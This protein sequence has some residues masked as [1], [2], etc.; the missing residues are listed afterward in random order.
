[1]ILSVLE[2]SVNRRDAKGYLQKYTLP[3]PLSVTE[4]PKFIQGDEAETDFPT[5]EPP[6]NVAIVKL[7]D[8]QFLD[9]KV[10]HGVGKTLAQLRALGL[11]SVVVVDCGA[12]EG[13]QLVGNEALRLCEAIDP[14]TKDGCKIVENIFTKDRQQPPEVPDFLSHEIRVDDA[15]H[16]S[17]ALQHNLIPILPSLASRDEYAAPSPVDSGEIILALTKYFTGLQSPPVGQQGKDQ[18][19][20]PKKIATVE[21]II[22]LDPLGGT[23]L[24]GRWRACHRF[25]NL[26][27]EYSPLL[28][29]LKGPEGSPSAS[30]DHSSIAPKTHAANLSLIKEALSLLPA[31]SSGLITTPLAA[32][33][34][35]DAPALGLRDMV[36]TR[37][38]QNPLL[39]NLLTDKP[40]YSSS[41]PIQRV[42]QSPQDTISTPVS[43]GTTL[44][45]RGV[46]LSIFPD[47]RLNPWTP[48]KPGTPQLRL[49]DMC[50]DLPK[51]VYL[52]EDSFGRKLDV[53][54]YLNRVQDNLA[55]VII[56]G[57]YEGGAIL[58]W[59]RPPGYTNDT[60]SE[61]G[62]FVP[63]LDKFAVLRSRQGSGG[64]ADILFNAMVQDCF[65]AGVCWRSRKD[66]PV[67]KWYFERSLGTAKLDGCSWT[68]FWTTPGLEGR[69]PRLHDYEGVC[70]GVE[71]SWADNKHILD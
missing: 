16:L 6:V 2:A 10:L 22:L 14:F 19:P 7:R 65:P 71:P 37:K 48:P 67:N 3:N 23:P 25:I 40:V 70:R 53:Q 27:Q 26:E 43:S 52:I 32:A 54:D 60:A 8:P 13:R 42:R 18:N 36:T 41:L 61:S 64:V 17:S 24:P 5:V 15:G 58:T 38:K 66:N 59:E 63:Y 62:V 33:N 34:L 51:L 45:K 68:M 56:A 46:P 50:I 55:G 57:D 69:N 35:D 21:R 31:T 9:D 30:D 44:L 12:E 4:A 1:M 47:P 39:H 28:K 49:T 11:L 29:Q 20:A